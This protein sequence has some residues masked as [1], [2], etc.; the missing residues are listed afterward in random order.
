MCKGPET[1]KRAQVFEDVKEGL[2]EGKA[3]ER[4]EEGIRKEA[5][6]QIT[7]SYVGHGKEPEF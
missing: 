5:S 1:K 7:Q 3:E 4:M 2:C 6:S